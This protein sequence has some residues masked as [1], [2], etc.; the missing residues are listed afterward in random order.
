MRPYDGGGVLRRLRVEVDG[1]QVASLQQYRAVDLDLS[2]GRHTVVGHMDWVSSASLD[3]D[4]ADG[5]D[6][7]LEV[8]LPLLPMW[9]VLQRPQRTLSIRRL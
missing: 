7:Q 5:E 6:V 8:A 4:L 1:R 2:P 3:L 9:Q